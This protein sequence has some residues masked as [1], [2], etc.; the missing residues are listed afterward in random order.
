MSGLMQL[1]ELKQKGEGALAQDEFNVLVKN[2][3]TL[4]ATR[5]Y[6]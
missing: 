2:E 1:F 3:L 6:A 4:T 5:G